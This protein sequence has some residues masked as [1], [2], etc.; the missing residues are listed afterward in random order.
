MAENKKSVILYIDLIHTFEELTDEEAGKLIK[1]F[2]RYVND[3]NP[4]PP[5]RLTKITFEPIKQQLKRDLKKWDKTRKK[6]SDAGKTGANKRWQTMA[7]DSPAITDMA[8]IADNVSDTVTDSVNVNDNVSVI[9]AEQTVLGN[10]IAFETICIKTHTDEKTARDALRCYH[11]W[12]SEND[13]YPKKRFSVFAGFE[14]WLLKENK[15]NGNK[16]TFT[17]SNSKPGA[18][19]A[20]AGK[21]DW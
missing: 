16:Q 4:E 9:N 11:L 18:S 20:R 17:S 5:D 12:L 6:R 14:K 2:F 1:H 15:T 19:E 7:S 10:M 3:K 13:K 21:S 8:K